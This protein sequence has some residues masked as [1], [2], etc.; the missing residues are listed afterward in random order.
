MRL[1]K[2]LQ[3]VLNV[4]HVTE[5]HS[6]ANTGVTAVVQQLTANVASSLLPNGGVYIFAMGAES[7]APAQGV[8]LDT[9][10]IPAIGRGWRWAPGLSR[11]LRDLIETYCI[12][13]VHLHGV[14]MAPQRIGGEAAHEMGVPF[15]VSIHGM[16][17]PWLWN[18]QGRRVK[19]KKGLY[20]R[21]VGYPTLR[22]AAV[23]HAI[24]PRE[25][26]L[27]ATRFPGQRTEVIPNAIDIAH[28]DEQLAG[29][30]VEPVP[31]ILFLG[32]IHPIKGVDLLIRAFAAAKLPEPW[33][34]VVAGPA[35]SPEYLARLKAMVE[36]LGLQQLV[37]FVGPIYGNEKWEW[38]RRAWV[39]AVPSYSEV[40]GM[41]NLE[42][43]ACR[44]PTIT[45]HQTG[46]WDWEQGGGVLIHPDA[47]ELERALKLAVAWGVAERVER[48]LASRRLVEQKYS[49]EVVGAQWL[50]LY[51]D[52]SGKA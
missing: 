39:V 9:L 49:W 23:I 5:D 28:V 21:M 27:L 33:R 20:W 8:V 7:E 45:T 18:K 11:R 42:A 40:V 2:G 25:R 43:S 51:R 30:P 10:P 46:L 36:Q 37:D 47:E 24:T 12:D 4:L 29:G 35:E 38:V 26:D 48:G 22:K 3:S 31:V 14:W 52:L 32:R 6:R 13:L 16:M 15:L 50:E 19:Y 1:T 41:V 17:E 44:T 34:L